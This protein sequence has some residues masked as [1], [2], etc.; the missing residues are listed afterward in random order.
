MSLRAADFTVNGMTSGLL[1]FKSLLINSKINAVN[2][3]MLIRRQMTKLVDLI[4]SLNH[5]IRKFN[6]T[7]QRL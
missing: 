5:D 7:V 6:V 1:L 4:H 2:D 3:P